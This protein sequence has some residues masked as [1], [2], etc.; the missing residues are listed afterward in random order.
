M[1]CDDDRKKCSRRRHFERV[2][3]E[4]AK[5]MEAMVSFGE[6]TT[7]QVYTRNNH[8]LNAADRGPRRPLGREESDA[9][10]NRRY[11]SVI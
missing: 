7:Q 8:K 5:T 9:H 10:I 2:S 1:D 4:L 3:Y 11:F 6:E